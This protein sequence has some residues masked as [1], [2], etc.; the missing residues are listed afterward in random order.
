MIKDTDFFHVSSRKVTVDMVELFL[1]PEL[2]AGYN[3]VT[4]HLQRILK[5]VIGKQGKPHVVDSQNPDDV[6]NRSI[7][8]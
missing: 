7:M 1:V 2:T 3:R 4:P 6:S 8:L 5:S